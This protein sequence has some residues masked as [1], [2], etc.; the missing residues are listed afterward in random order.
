MSNP[1]KGRQLILSVSLVAAL[2]LSFEQGFA[3]QSKSSHELKIFHTQSAPSATLL[4]HGTAD[5]AAMGPS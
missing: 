1:L 4:I 2:L 3:D 5:L